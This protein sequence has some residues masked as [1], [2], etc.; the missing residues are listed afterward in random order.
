MANATCLKS[1]ARPHKQVQANAATG[2]NVAEDAA[3]AETVVAA[4]ATIGTSYFLK[5][6]EHVTAEKDKIQKNAEGPYEGFG[7]K[8]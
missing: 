7:S 6:N 3:I 2:A 1:Q 8:R 4:A 5:Q